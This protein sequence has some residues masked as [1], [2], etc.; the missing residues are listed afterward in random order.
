MVCFLIPVVLAVVA[1]L[2]AWAV[3]YQGN[4]MPLGLTVARCVELRQPPQAV[5]DVV[6][7]FASVPTWNFLVVGVERLSDRNGHEVWQE[8]NTGGPALQ[9]E[10]VEDAPPTRLVRSIVSTNASFTGRWE[11]AIAPADAGTRVTIVEHSEIPNPYFRFIFRTF[12]NPAVHLENYLRALAK[13]FGE[14]ETPVREP[15]HHG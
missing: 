3:W 5:W 1:G 14:P 15:A 9:L 4:R 10:V 13:K 6:R 11:F 8:K 7:D 12:M 2:L